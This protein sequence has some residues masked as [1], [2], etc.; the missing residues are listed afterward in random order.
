MT[1]GML[2]WVTD[3]AASMATDLEELREIE[4]LLRDAE[5]RLAA[6]GTFRQRT[7]LQMTLFEVQRSLRM[8]ELADRQSEPLPKIR[9]ESAR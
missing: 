5:A 8:Q 2:L 3:K 9:D 7:L 1:L 6:F 4:R